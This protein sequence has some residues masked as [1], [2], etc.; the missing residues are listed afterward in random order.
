[1][2]EVYAPDGCYLSVKLDSAAIE[3]LHLEIDAHA[4][5]RA[6]LKGC[7][8]QTRPAVLRAL[9]DVHVVRGDK[10]RIHPPDALSAGSANLTPEKP[11]ALT[12]AESGIH[13][14]EASLPS[15]VHPHSR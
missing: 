14:E 10:L 8:G 6:I 5:R 7:P 15:R 12:C 9:K 4:V 11:A 1:M 2:K 3:K 13:M